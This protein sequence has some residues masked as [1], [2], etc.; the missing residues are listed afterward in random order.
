MLLDELRQTG[1][2][3][4]FL[5]AGNGE[6]GLDYLRAT[7]VDLVL[8]DLDMPCMSGFELLRLLQQ[9]EKLSEIPVIMLTG[10]DNQ[11]AKI[12][13]LE[14]GASDY[15]T[16]PFDP[17]ELIARVKVQLKIKHLQDG[18]R[19]LANTDPLTRLHNRRYLF[20]QLEKERE[21]AIETGTELSLALLDIDHFKR[22]NDTYGHQAGD[23]VLIAVADALRRSLRSSDLAAR[24]GGE[25]FV[26]MLPGTS[27]VDSFQVVEQLRGSIARLVIPLP[28]AEGHVTISAG[29]A[30]LVGGS[31]ITVDALVRA[32]DKALY[33][34]K[35]SGRNRVETAAE[36]F[37]KAG[38]SSN[39]GLHR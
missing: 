27:L 30:T 8:C 25:E 15:V 29:V 20:E 9:D 14:L 31:A 7:E 17:A 32:A 36:T 10:Y 12:R 35:E 2:F 5:E 34:A 23:Q 37:K 11:K 33:R 13:G 28:A 22:F 39:S 6:E 4:C 38:N 3:D 19:T 16:K 24:F 18:L 1:L 26:L 21:R